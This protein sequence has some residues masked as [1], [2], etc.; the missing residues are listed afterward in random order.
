MLK[1]WLLLV[2][3]SL[4]FGLFCVFNL[5]ILPPCG[6][7]EGYAQ[8][9]RSLCSLAYTLN[10]IALCGQLSLL[11]IKYLNGSAFF[12]HMHDTQLFHIYQQQL[13][14]HGFLFGKIS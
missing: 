13:H 6:D 9:W 4:K 2:L 11:I 14:T 5:Q 8:N 1:K 10:F 7:K 3:A 12:F